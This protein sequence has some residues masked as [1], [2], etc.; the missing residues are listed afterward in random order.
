MILLL[1]G[2]SSLHKSQSQLKEV[3]AVKLNVSNGENAENKIIFLTFQMTLADSIK[4]TYTFTVTNTIFAEGILNKNSF[5]SDMPVEPYNLYCEITDDTKKR[6]DMIKVQNPLLKVFEYSPDKTILEKRL[7]ISNTGELFLRFQ[8]TKNSKYL[9][10][11]KPQPDLQTLKKI[12]Y[13]QI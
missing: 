11:F 2:C 9:T 7:F 8:L 12:Y 4:D 6:V 13:A 5:I 10:I 1:T 3:Q